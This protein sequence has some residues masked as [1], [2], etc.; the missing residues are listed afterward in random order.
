MWW[1][2]QEKM[3]HILLSDL[4]RIRKWLTQTKSV[5]NKANLAPYKVSY[6]FSIAR[7]HTR[8]QRSSYLPQPCSVR[9]VALY[10]YLGKLAHCCHQH[11]DNVE[12]SQIDLLCYPKSF[13]YL[14]F[15]FAQIVLHCC[16]SAIV[17]AVYAWFSVIFEK[18]VWWSRIPL[19][20]VMTISHFLAEKFAT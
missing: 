8:K 16:W 5:N 7:I 14:V 1:Q 4:R 20:F 11:C 6:T 12:L 19:I 18:V 13:I 9:Q 2:S 15:F 3:T 10:C 17:V